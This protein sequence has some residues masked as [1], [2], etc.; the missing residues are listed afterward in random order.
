MRRGDERGEGDLCPGPQSHFQVRPSSG[1]RPGPGSKGRGPE[2]QVVGA[3][4]PN[5][6]AAGSPVRAPPHHRRRRGGRC[7]HPSHGSPLGL[8]QRGPVPGTPPHT[9]GFPASRP[10]P[11]HPAGP[12]SSP[13][14]SWPPYGLPSS[15]KQHSED[16][17]GGGGA[18]LALGSQHLKD[19]CALHSR[20]ANPH[21]PGLSLPSPVPGLPGTLTLRSDG[22]RPRCSVHTQHRLGGSRRCWGDWGPTANTSPAQA[23]R[24]PQGL[25]LSPTLTQVPGDA[26]CLHTTASANAHCAS[27]MHQ[28]LP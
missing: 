20:H 24:P 8:W 19:T 15:S 7:P 9:P 1:A 22:P 18:A 11:T 27:I 17:R 28:A 26:T 4:S 25:A 5:S 12:S 23:L 10:K 13:G 6:G 16:T 21:A 3:Q 14:S 2:R